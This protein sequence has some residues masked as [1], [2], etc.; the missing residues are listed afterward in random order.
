MFGGTFGAQ[1]DTD[2]S[3]TLGF[4][5][6]MHVQPLVFDFLANPRA[7]TAPMAERTE[8]TFDAWEAGAARE[9][10]ETAIATIREALK[11]ERELRD[12]STITGQHL[13]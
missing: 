6:Q 7:H 12:T 11:K 9:E 5:D 1:P 13:S 2:P 10:R 4:Q 3:G 8:A